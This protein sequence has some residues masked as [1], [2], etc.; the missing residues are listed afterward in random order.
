MTNRKARD[1]EYLGRHTITCIN[2]PCVLMA[3]PRR[4]SKQVVATHVVPSKQ[5]ADAGCDWCPASRN[6][7]ENNMPLRPK[8]LQ[9]L[10]ATCITVGHIPKDL[11]N[12]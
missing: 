1:Y 10:I 8:R 4:A 11:S 7:Q 5:V 2:R 9:R 3:Q 12:N 6:A